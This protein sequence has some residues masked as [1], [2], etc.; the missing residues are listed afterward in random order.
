VIYASAINGYATL[1]LAQPSPDMRPM[2]ETILKHVPPPHADEIDGPL[3]LQ[4]SALDYSSYV[5]RIGIGRLQRGRL[6]PAQQVLVMYGQADAEGKFRAR[7][8][9]DCQSRPGFRFPRSGTGTRWTKRSP[10]TSC[11]SPESTTCRSAARSPMSRSPKRC[12]C[13]KI[14]EPTLNMTFMVNNSPLRRHRRQVRHQSADWRTPAQGTADQH[15]SARRGNDRHRQ[16][17]W[18]PDVANCI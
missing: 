8:T 9:E 13:C 4:I 18:F 11:W 15:G 2:F 6:K 7:R 14:D 5:G 17:S 16:L 12:R 1:D 3:Q 10:A